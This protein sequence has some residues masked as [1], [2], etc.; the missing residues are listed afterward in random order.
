MVKINPYWDFKNL[1]QIKD[2]EEVS[3]EFEAMFVRMI[4]KEFRKTIPNGLF[5]TSFSSK[6]YW[7]MFDMQMAE[8]ISSSDQFGLKSYI[9]KALEA[10]N[11]YSQESK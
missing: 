6:M 10:Y 2:V 8:A 3:K 7:D 1:Q 11:R 4:L 9:Q 5:N